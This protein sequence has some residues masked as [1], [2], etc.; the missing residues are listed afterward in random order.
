MW[1]PSSPRVFTSLLLCL[2]SPPL[3]VCRCLQDNK[4]NRDFS[5]ACLREIAE[6]EMEASKVS[7]LSVPCMQLARSSGLPRY[8][9]TWLHP[10]SGLPP[11]LP[12]QQ[13]LRQGRGRP[14]PRAMLRE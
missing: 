9:L 8:N 6:Y 5:R 1:N 3:L 10:P 4:V 11:Q 7:I 14:L 12:A 13:E 2:S